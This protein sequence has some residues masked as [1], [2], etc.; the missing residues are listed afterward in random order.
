MELI[1]R[2]HKE[3]KTTVIMITHEKD[4]AN[5]AERQITLEDGLIQ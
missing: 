3:T 4:I 5:Y 1:S 2:F